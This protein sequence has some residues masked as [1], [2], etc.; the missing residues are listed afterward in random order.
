VA[1]IMYTS[2]TTGHPKGILPPLS[3][4][5]FG[6]GG[7]VDAL[8][9]MYGFGVGTRYL[10]PAPLYHAAPLG[11]SMGAQRAGGTVV[12]LERFDPAVALAAIEE[13]RV[14]HAQFVPTHFVRMLKLDEAS[15]AA[16]D[17]SSLRF[18]VHGWPWTSTVGGWLLRILLRS[19]TGSRWCRPWTPAAPATW[20]RATGSGHDRWSGSGSLRRSAQPA[21]GP[22]QSARRPSPGLGA[23]RDR[24]ERSGTAVHPPG[25]D[26]P[27]PPCR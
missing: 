13:H 27:R 8:V 11:W 4:A 7:V 6:T 17:V 15:R 19:R 3:G 23:P 22:C 26:R 20:S 25:D 18:V 24:R 9:A 16:H 14:T 2:G 5:P 12:V 10:V 21:P 1:V